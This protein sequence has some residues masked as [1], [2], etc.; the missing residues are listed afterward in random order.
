MKWWQTVDV[1]EAESNV[2]RQ[3][4]ESLLDRLAT[5]ARLR[6]EQME[7]EAQ[8]AG[9]WNAQLASSFT[10]SYQRATAADEIDIANRKLSE[11]GLIDQIPISESTIKQQIMS[12]RTWTD[13]VVRQAEEASWQ[14]RIAAIRKE[15][16]HDAKLQHKQKGGDWNSLTYAQKQQHIDDLTQQYLGERYPEEVTPAYGQVG[17]ESTVAEPSLAEPMGQPE[18][19]ARGIIGAAHPVGALLEPTT[20]Q[21]LAEGFRAI[22][23]WAF[24]LIF[25]QAPEIPV[26]AEGTHIP[27]YFPETPTV[28]GKYTAA[29]PL[30][31]VLF[32][33]I[34]PYGDMPT[35]E[36]VPVKEAAETFAQS[37]SHL[38][39]Q[40]GA[41]VLQM[42]QGWGGASVV[43]QDWADEYIAAA[44]VDMDKFVEGI[45]QQ[46]PDSGMLME[47]AQVSRNLAFSTVSMG[48]GLVVGLPIAFAPV[49]FA[50]VAAWVAGS[51]ASGWA[52]YQMTTY[53]IMQEYLELKNEEKIAQ[54]GEQLTL[55]EENALKL[56]FS[57]K[58]RKYGLWEAVPEGISNL[59]FGQILIGPLGKMIG[60]PMAA[61][62][63]AKL[64]MMYGEELLTETITQKGQ[65][66]I[67]VEA[68][69]RER[70]ITWVEAFKE[71]APQ[72]FLLTTILGGSGQVAVSSQQGIRRITNSLKNEIGE[73]HPLYEKIK[74]GIESEGVEPKAIIPEV[75]EEVAAPV[76][77]KVTLTETGLEEGLYAINLE[78]VEESVGAVKVF[79]QEDA[80]FA[81]R[82]A[83][84][85]KGALT[86]SFLMQL[87]AQLTDM[88]RDAGKPNLR[89][90][91]RPENLGLYKRAGYK[92]EGDTNVV[93]K[94]VIVPVA[95]VTPVAMAEPETFTGIVPEAVEVTVEGLEP[96]KAIR[97]IDANFR[98][99]QVTHAQ[100]KKLLVAYVNEHL[101]L[102]IRG[103]MLAAVKNAKTE[104]DL[105]KAIKL[106]EKYGEQYA[107]TT[108]RKRITS[109]L[110]TKRIAAKAQ[111]GKFTAEAQ[112]KLNTIK[113]NLNRDREEV[114]D[115]IL[116][117]IQ[118]ADE[119]KIT[120]EDADAANEILALAGI[121]GMSSQELANTLAYVRALKETGRGLRA[122]ERE[123]LKERMDTLR[124]DITNILTGGKGIKVGV[125]TVD[126]RDLEV[127]R[128][129]WKSK[130]KSFLTNWQFGMDD[131]LDVLSKYDKT[132]KPFGSVISQIG[133]ALHL[134]R[135]QQFAGIRN[136]T[137]RVSSKVKEIYGFKKGRE[138]NHFLSRFIKEKI[139]LGTFATTE[140]KM[141]VLSLTKDQ[142]VEKY[143]QLQD[144][145][146][147]ETFS[148]GMKWTDEMIG[149]VKDSMTAEDI[150]FADW[151][152]SFYRE[153]GQTIKPHYEAKYH[154]PWPENPYY[155]PLNRD[156]EGGVYEH[157]LMLKDNFRY[158]GVTNNS[159]K[160]RKKNQVPL[161]FNGA[162]QVLVNHILQ[163]EH[164]KAFAQPMKQARMVFRNKDV[165]TAIRQYHGRDILGHLDR[166]LDQIA[167]D[168]LDKALINRSMDILRGHFT[169]AA[170]GLKSI[171]AIKQGGSLPAYLTYEE[172]PV[173]D[174]FEGVA[175]FWEN[176]IAHYKE[177]RDASGY[178]TDRWGRGHE[179]DIRYVM[180]KGLTARLSNPKN[181]RDLLMLGIRGVD[182]VTTTAGSWAVYRSMQK[183]G[184]S[185][186]N[187]I[188]H[189]EIATKRSQPSFGLE[190]MAAL[191]K[192]GLAI[193]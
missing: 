172:M 180:Q 78:G 94:E 109:E 186:E 88:A 40:V 185:K 89:I 152:L 117:N 110:R 35:V 63:T 90:A 119:G 95:E 77:P 128:L 47:L 182:T 99:R 38:P 140:N 122:A 136:Y 69:L 102:A 30:H 6:R 167:R 124:E 33:A 55:E 125:G 41:S 67:E 113:A 17:A 51:A 133:I 74:E 193:I 183:Q 26:D 52:A 68:G 1:V 126:T 132:S 166:H 159:L 171:V 85:E 11:L 9:V 70:N 34:E 3:K 21:N 157:I 19:V 57:D 82:I 43:N 50:R 184:Q 143:L 103:K 44:N 56:D 106:A 163:M 83:V 18:R 25:P 177:M 14:D 170:L 173:G 37:L 2:S 162:T 84:H 164:F 115:E 53:Q 22:G 54:T 131:V 139:T 108:L 150:K 42:T 189:A 161:R 8:K 135:S 66:A 120:Y 116:Q 144:P 111:Y 16:E 188:L 31:A 96:I 71:I 79:L 169:L 129:D 141:V 86:R 72:T 160:A 27:Q 20:R 100:T 75:A 107:Q 191:R 130:V 146:L 29:H 112:R 32:P 13:S 145:T 91:V 4:T 49:P 73:K 15:A 187:A 149:A 101:P 98:Q 39:P 142:I 24:G 158:A 153:Y 155:S 181:W 7:R 81:N 138:F 104:L 46:Y 45:M 61:K 92:Q 168:G 28:S 76:A 59:L 10:R 65:S 121:K 154:Q 190:D 87:D 175:N 151:M 147:A 192:H 105:T 60:G 127:T 58:A 134:A 174:F 36:A 123:A 12:G 23:K 114:K 5:Q 97:K 165:R 148:I 93:I 156:L 176:P 178:F 62:L 179:R 137:E 64:A 118:K 80:L 48:T